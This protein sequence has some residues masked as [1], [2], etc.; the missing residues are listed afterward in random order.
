MVLYEP[1]RRLD[2]DMR[3]DLA[4]RLVG[5]RDD[6]LSVLFARLRAHGTASV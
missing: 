2:A 6:G 1:E 4:E 3:Q 5:A